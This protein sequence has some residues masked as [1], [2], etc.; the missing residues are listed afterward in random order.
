MITITNSVFDAQGADRKA[1]V[2]GITLS[3][4][5]DVT[6]KDCTFKNQGYS[7][8]LNNCAGSVLVED[9]DFEC[10]TM[11][12]PIEGSQ[13]VDNGDVVVKRCAFNGAPGN[14]Y[15]NFYQVAEGSNHHV[16]DCT[17]APTVDNNV[18]RISNRTSAS[19]NV[20]VKDCQ[21]NFAEGEATEYTGF[22]LC[23][24]YTNKNGV[25]QDF[26]KVRV[27][28]DNVLCDGEK[29]TKDGAAKGSI[30]YVYEDGA[31]IITGTNDPVVIVK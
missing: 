2:Y 28:L 15:I 16:E 10:D 20:E 11:Y 23:Q 3:G 29:V 6:I 31:G 5:E 21:Y 30:F 13:S 19:T 27:T 1:K 26:T 22:L 12:N 18:I 14:N 9:C 4:S 17:F 24:D 25:K 7:A 8:I